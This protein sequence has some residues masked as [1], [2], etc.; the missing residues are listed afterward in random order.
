MLPRQQRRWICPPRRGSRPRREVRKMTVCIAALAAAGDCIVCVADKSISYS[1]VVW[2]SDCKKIIPLFP[3]FNAC[4]LTAG[5]DRYLTRLIRKLHH[6][7][8]YNDSLSDT[9]AFLEQAYKECLTEIREIELL[10]PRV[11][12][13]EQFVDA[14]SQS[15]F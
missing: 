4:A 3:L 6:H 5:S 9:V 1:D 8:G 2:D 13:R 15:D 12:N 7:C 11:L 14:V 10:S